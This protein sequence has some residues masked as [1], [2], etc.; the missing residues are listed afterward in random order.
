[1]TGVALPCNDNYTAHGWRSS[2]VTTSAEKASRVRDYD[3]V[4]AAILADVENLLSEFTSAGSGIFLFVFSE[5]LCMAT[6]TGPGARP[7]MSW[8]P[9]RCRCRRS[10]LYTR[11][12]VM[13]SSL[14]ALGL[15][16]SVLR[17]HRHEPTLYAGRFSTSPA[18]I[19]RSHRARGAIAGGM[20]WTLVIANVCERAGSPTASSHPPEEISSTPPPPP[21]PHCCY[22]SNAF[23]DQPWKITSIGLRSWAHGPI[24]KSWY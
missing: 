12:R 20:Y 16:G 17:R 7:G 22:A 10:R 3:A 18:E 2:G 6:K 8:Q 9:W 14:P 4:G 19:C 11:E 21:P 13:A 23:V 5:M 1:M 24:N 15:S